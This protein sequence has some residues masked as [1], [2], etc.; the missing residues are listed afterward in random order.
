MCICVTAVPVFPKLHFWVPNLGSGI[1]HIQMVTNPTRSP[2]WPLHA[3]SDVAVGAAKTRG[4]PFSARPDPIRRQP[5]SLLFPFPSCFPR[6]CR[7]RPR[8]LRRPAKGGGHSAPTRG[9]E[10]V[11]RRLDLPPMLLQEAP[12]GDG[13]Y[14]R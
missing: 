7:R 8:L 13:G 6:H 5:D 3:G 2:T 10:K 11:S 4:P 1:I 14:V 12:T 9:K